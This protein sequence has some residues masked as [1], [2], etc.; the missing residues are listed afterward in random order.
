MLMATKEMLLLILTIAYTGKYCT[1]NTLKF[2]LFVT[3]HTFLA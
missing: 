2:D 1:F 3:Q